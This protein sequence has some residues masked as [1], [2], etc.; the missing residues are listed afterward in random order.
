MRLLDATLKNIQ[1]FDPSLAVR[2]QMRLNSLTK[3]LGSLG[4]LEILALQCA[5]ITQ[6][7]RPRVDNKVLFVCD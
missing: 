4:R 1:P 2:V 6:S 3:P 5:T 7:E